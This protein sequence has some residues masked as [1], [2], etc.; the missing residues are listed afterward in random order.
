MSARK[1]SDRYQF[2]IGVTRQNFPP[3]SP[4]SSRS[5]YEYRST[6]SQPPE[7]PSNTVRFGESDRNTA[8]LG[9][10][11]RVSP[12][13]FQETT[14]S[15]PFTVGLPTVEASRWTMLYSVP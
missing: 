14:A 5:R 11:G 13:M 9:L 7:P 12:V 1:L 15:P 3:C 6:A 4:A 8:V 10:Y 2:T